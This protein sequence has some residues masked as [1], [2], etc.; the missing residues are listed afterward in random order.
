MEKSN[1][2]ISSLIIAFSLIISVLIYSNNL[3][4]IQ[5]LDNT[6]V[7]TGSSTKIVKSDLAKLNSSFFRTVTESELKKGY[8]F[9]QEDEKKVINFL[10]ENNIL[11]DEYEIYPVSM[12]KDYYYDKAIDQDP[13][14]N[15]SQRVVITSSDIEKIKNLSQK[16]NDLIKLDVIYQTNAPEYYYT[17]LPDE[18][19]NLLPE[20]VLDA[21]KRAE[22]IAKSADRG[23]NTIKSADMGVVQ[24]MQP[25]ST[26]IASYGAYDTSTVEKEIMITVRVN[27]VLD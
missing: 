20:A 11:E 16:A 5:N 17:K 21:R 24:I 3:F 8:A 10:N 6:L 9:M 1:I 14:Y 4:K 23:V 26:D 12:Y 19:I 2:V 7:V 25:N 27:F 22:A 15:L 13:R 18:R